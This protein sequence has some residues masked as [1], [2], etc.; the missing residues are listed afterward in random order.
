MTL[1]HRT[2]AAVQ[3]IW[4]PTYAIAKSILRSNSIEHR[5][6]EWPVHLILQG[7]KPC[8]YAAMGTKVKIT[9]GRCEKDIANCRSFQR[10]AALDLARIS[11]PVTISIPAIAAAVSASS[12]AIFFSDPSWL[13]RLRG[14]KKAALANPCR[15]R[16]T[17]MFSF[18]VRSSASLARSA[19]TLTFLNKLEGA[20]A[21]VF[22]L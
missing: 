16:S 18:L 8:R 2:A 15:M 9:S 4:K 6:D 5:T 22:A 21:A 14:S 19:L 1:T 3:Q 12:S 10:N 17:E 13:K 11:E 20:A 7:D